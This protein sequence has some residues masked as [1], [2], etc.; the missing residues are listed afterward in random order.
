M[1][2]SN[3]CVFYGGIRCRKKV[4]QNWFQDGSLLKDLYV[5]G[6]LQHIKG[7]V[8]ASN[9]VHKFGLLGWSK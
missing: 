1:S 6:G 5:G 2:L 7:S 4:F 8:Y 3:Y 9:D